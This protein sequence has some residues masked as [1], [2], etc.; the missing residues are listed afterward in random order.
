[1]SGKSS[2]NKNLTSLS[3]EL[4][5]MIFRN[6]HLED[7]LHVSESNTRLHY[8]ISDHFRR[9]FIQWMRKL[10]DCDLEMMS[11]EKILFLAIERYVKMN[12]HPP[13]IQTLIELTQSI[14]RCSSDAWRNIKVPIAIDEREKLLKFFYQQA[15][16]KLNDKERKIIFVLTLLT[17]LRSLCNSQFYIVHPF[18]R[19]ANLRIFCTI[20]NIFFV[21]PFYKFIYEWF[22][23]DDDSIGI[24]LMFVKF[25][26]M[27]I[28]K[29]SA[30]T[31]LLSPMQFNRTTIIFGSEN[32][33]NKRVK[34]H[35]RI[36]CTILMSANREM[37]QSM[38][39][40]MLN[41]EDFNSI[42]KNADNFSM[43]FE[44]SCPRVKDC[45]YD[46]NIKL[47]HYLIK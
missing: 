6:L 39:Q 46:R 21:I 43:H 29:S 27:K 33:F 2:Y 20:H 37:I 5:S 35:P 38:K 4:T 36:E 30:W 24:L 23:F 7:K 34:T 41:G 3:R 13:Y 14:E 10:E 12:F 15:N 17:M 16:E 44:F 8:H 22:D 40:F 28:A 9:K 18:N 31:K 19:K 32:P 45:E 25:L 26:E 1:M 11:N 42:M 47:C